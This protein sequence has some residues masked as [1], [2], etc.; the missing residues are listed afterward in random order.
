MPDE[1]YIPNFIALIGMPGSGKSELAKAIG[2]K[3]DGT[4]EV[5]DG[6]AE[7]ISLKGRLGLGMAASYFSNL[8]V[9]VNRVCSERGA[10][11]NKPKHIVVCG[12]HIETIAYASINGFINQQDDEQENALHIQ[13]MQ[14]FMR[15]LGMLVKDTFGYNHIFY[16]PSNSEDTFIKQMDIELTQ[17]L[18]TLG[19]DYVTLSGT[20]EEQLE[21][22]LK[23][24]NEITKE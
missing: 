4:Y 9:A 18:E 14:L 12:T 20:P 8:A 5:V 1:A 23:E 2:E 19:T 17:A 6:Y 7:E 13:R 16:L 3:L 22:A 21:N 11:E 15:F 10:M 24:I